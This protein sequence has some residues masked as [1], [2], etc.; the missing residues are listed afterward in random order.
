MR[1]PSPRKFVNG[2]PLYASRRFGKPKTF[3][4]VVLGDFGA[5]VDGEVQ[6]CHSAQPNIYKAPEL[7]VRADWSY[8]VDIWNVGVLVSLHRWL[9]V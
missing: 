8:P 6:R 9:T 7:L 4:R 2:V 5:A 1:S 3:G